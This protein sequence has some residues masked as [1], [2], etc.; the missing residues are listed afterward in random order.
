MAFFFAGFG[1]RALGIMSTM[2]LRALLDSRQTAA[3]AADGV[4]DIEVPMV[5]VDKRLAA[6]QRG[7]VAHDA[8]KR[9]LQEVGVTTP[10]EKLAE[11]I[12]KAHELGLVGVRERRH[13]LFFNREANR[14]KHEGTFPF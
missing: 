7:L 12:A 9:R 4:A 2:T 11:A 3:F 5:E 6:M 8:V 10:P 13:L 14:A 1:V